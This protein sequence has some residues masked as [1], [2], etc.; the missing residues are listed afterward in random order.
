MDVLSACGM[1]S[2]ETMKSEAMA[3]IAVTF[4]SAATEELR[5]ALLGKKGSI[6]AL[7]QTLGSL[8]PAER[9]SFGAAIN[10]LKEEIATALDARKKTLLAAEQAEKLIREKVDI[11]L[12]PAPLAVGSIHPLQQTLREITSFFSRLG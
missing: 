5:V 6:T 9:K 3:A 12:S 10:L 7:L 4:S 8:P 11:T 1:N 2:L